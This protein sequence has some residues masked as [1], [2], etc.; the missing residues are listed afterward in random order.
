M[1]SMLPGAR[2]R[3]SSTARRDAVTDRDV[4]LEHPHRHDASPRR[5]RR[6]PACGVKCSTATGV[7]P[8]ALAA[9][10]SGQTHDVWYVSTAWKIAGDSERRMRRCA[11]NAR[12]SRFERS[13]GTTIA[14][15]PARRPARYST[16]C[17]CGPIA[18]TSTS[19]RSASMR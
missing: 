3:S 16:T 11:G 13:G 14:S 12:I 9:A 18:T 4:G 17:A 7:T 15:V 19:G 2:S 1:V 10:N 5:A 6:V 8:P